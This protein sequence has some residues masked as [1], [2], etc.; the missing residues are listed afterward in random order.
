M[1]Y[2]MTNSYFW[3]WE[4]ITGQ[5]IYNFTRVAFLAWHQAVPQRLRQNIVAWPT[6]SLL[7][8]THAWC[9]MHGPHWLQHVAVNHACEQL[10]KQ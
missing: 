5:Y 7:H 8:G 10:Y 2:R 6:S 4:G 1:A 3:H 9:A